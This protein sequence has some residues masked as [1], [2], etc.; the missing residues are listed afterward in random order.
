[1]TELFQYQPLTADVQEI[2]LVRIKPSEK[3]SAHL[4]L[5]IK[6]FPLASAP[7]YCALSY[8]WGAPY[9]GLSPE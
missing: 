8:T 1:M 7:P 9:R 5:T 3:T 2:R 6:H 4:G